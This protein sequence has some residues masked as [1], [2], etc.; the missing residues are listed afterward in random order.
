[1]RGG[2]GEGVGEGAI[3]S[4]DVETTLG[5][6]YQQEQLVPNKVSSSHEVLLKILSRT[7]C[8]LMKSPRS[9]SFTPAW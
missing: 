8:F 5:G 4:K 1:M 3:P 6:N 7:L 9:L 2:V